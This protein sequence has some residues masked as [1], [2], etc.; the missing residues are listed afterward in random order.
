MVMQRRHLE[1]PLF[2]QFVRAHLQ[3]HRQGFQHEN[4]ADKRQQQL[5][6]DRDRHRPDRP[7]QRERPH[8]A[9]EHLRRVR[10]VPKKADAGPHHRPAEDGQLAHQRH[11][12]QL[13]VIGKHDVPAH[14]GQHGQGRR[15]D[16]GAADRQAVE[17]IGQVHRIARPD[18]DQYN[19]QDE[20][21]K[22][23]QM[24]VRHAGERRDAERRMDALQERHH[25]FGRVAAPR[26]HGHERDRHSRAHQNLV[27]GLSARRQPKI[28]PVH[29]LDIVVREPDRPEAESRQDHQPDHRVPQVGPQK[30]R[31]QDRDGNQHASHGR[32]AGFF[33]VRLRPVLADVLPDLELAQLINHKRPDKQ[34]DQERRKRSK[35]RPK[36]DVA[37]DA[38]RGE[39]GKEL[40]IEQPVQQRG[41]PE[42][43]GACLWYRSVVSVFWQNPPRNIL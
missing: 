38:E 22:C 3:N 20:W 2:A 14:I 11:P 34:R 10:V 29:H 12:L 6:L 28:A 27:A 36:R 19:K 24:K 7:A 17:P 26:L 9:H 31:Q 16:D 5:L 4:A 43:W 41:S 15:G 42:G 13:Q 40:L 1:N 30:R 35:S 33:L 23:Q 21:Q 25:Q 39:V 18:D 37:E 32:G 8:V